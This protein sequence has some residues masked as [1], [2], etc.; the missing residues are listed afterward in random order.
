MHTLLP[1][2]T[3]IYVLE[4][5]VVEQNVAEAIRLTNDWSLSSLRVETAVSCIVWKE[6]DSLITSVSCVVWKE[7]DCL[8]TSVPTVY[9]IFIFLWHSP[10]RMES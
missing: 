8:L 6:N 9:G 1:R 3:D 5:V 10:P 4:S 2:S 7:N